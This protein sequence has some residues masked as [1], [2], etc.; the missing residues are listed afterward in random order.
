MVNGTNLIVETEYVTASIPSKVRNSE[1]IESGYASATSPQSDATKTKISRPKTSKYDVR[2]ARASS[3]H[4]SNYSVAGKRNTRAEY[5]KASP[6]VRGTV[7]NGCQR[8]KTAH[9][10]IS[11]EKLPYED[12]KVQQPVSL[13][14]CYE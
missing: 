2:H 8:L 10:R 1:Q 14:F 7:I 13:F 3:S 9:S 5:R 11:V 12:I 6:E 4:R